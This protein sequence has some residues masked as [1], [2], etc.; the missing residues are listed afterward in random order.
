MSS[1]F[2]YYYQMPRKPPPQATDPAPSFTFPG[3]MA[4]AP[5]PTSIRERILHAAVDIL[6]G[7]G[8]RALTQQRVAEKAGVRQSHITYYF[9]AR[10]DLLRE[11]AAFGCNVMLEMLAGGVDSGILTIE[12]AREVFAADITD[13][14]FA[15][16]M[17]ALTV[18]SDEDERIKLWLAGFE[19]V[20]H[21]RLQETFHK[22][23]LNVTLDDVV[24]FHATLVGALIQD[25]GES[26]DA[27]LARARAITMRAFDMLVE[28]SKQRN[29]PT[30]PT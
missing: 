28:I 9:P 6:N 13:R 2:W 4:H 5:A 15:R 10:N 18:A 16:L 24:F 1:D 11:T 17:C 30:P 19:D 21:R 8:F 23:G 7:E 27:S 3:A 22:L 20:N 25:L 14:R 29:T 12:S 26:S